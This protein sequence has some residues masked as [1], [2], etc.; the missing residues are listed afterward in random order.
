MCEYDHLRI[1]F[2]GGLHIDEYP[3]EN[4][5]DI[6]C[7][8]DF[9]GIGDIT[10]HGKSRFYSGQWLNAVD[11]ATQFSNLVSIYAITLCEDDAPILLWEVKNKKHLSYKYWYKAATKIKMILNT[12]RNNRMESKNDGWYKDGDVND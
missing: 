10:F 6:N 4:K 7:P 11:F 8:N 9:N 5:V 2:I 12:T 1:Y 3:L